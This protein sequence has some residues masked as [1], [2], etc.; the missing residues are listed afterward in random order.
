MITPPYCT[1]E[2]IQF[3]VPQFN[4]NADLVQ[5]LTAEQDAIIEEATL[6]MRQALHGKYDLTTFTDISNIPLSIRTPTAIKG[7]MIALRGYQATFGDDNQI[8]QM[9]ALKESLNF[10]LSIIGNNSLLAD[11]GTELLP[12]F[13][14]ATT[15]LSP[16][17]VG[18]AEV[19]ENG[20][21]IGVPDITQPNV[22]VAD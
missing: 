9:D 1:F 15:N 2:D 13:N 12:T 20:S 14:P 21:R 18:I 16:I 7:A 17:P 22:A 8:G 6:F 10:Y 11:D 5:L 4:D 19:Y 3:K